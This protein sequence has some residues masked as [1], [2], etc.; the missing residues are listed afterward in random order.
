MNSHNG[1][2]KIITAEGL[3]KGP[4]HMDYNISRKLL[5]DINVFDEP[6]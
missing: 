4:Q 5:C 1:T 2:D 6:E 3:I